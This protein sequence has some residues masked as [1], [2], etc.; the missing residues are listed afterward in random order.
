[1]LATTQTTMEDPNKHRCVVE[2]PRK[3]KVQSPQAYFACAPHKM[4][5]ELFFKMPT[6][7]LPD[8]FWDE[9]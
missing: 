1:M 3:R 2:K 9:R 8:S 4:S 6:A 5:T 7:P